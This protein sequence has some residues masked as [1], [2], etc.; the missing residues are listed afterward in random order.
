MKTRLDRILLASHQ[1]K[2]LH[3]CLS[4]MW[5]TWDQSCRQGFYILFTYFYYININKILKHAV[6]VHL[7]YISIYYVTSFT[8]TNSRLILLFS[9]FLR[10]LCFLIRSLLW[11]YPLTA[12]LDLSSIIHHRCSQKDIYNIRDVC[13]LIWS[14]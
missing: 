10:E 12:H 14:I 11:I 6:A 5:S 1:G 7:K 4:Y 13:M 3:R 8:T 2:E 9:S